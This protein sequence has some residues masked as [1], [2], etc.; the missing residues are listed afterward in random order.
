MTAAA[1]PE[2]WLVELDRSEAALEALERTTPR[3]SDDIRARLAA[4]AAEDARRE[5]RLA[6][7]ALRILLERRLGSGIRNTPF[8]VAAKGKPSLAGVDAS[9][10]LAHT[11]QTALIGI[12]DAGPIGVD[13]ERSRPLWMPEARRAPIEAE[14]VALAAGAPLAEPDPDARFLKAWVRIEAAA[15]ADGS[16]VGARLEHLRPGRERVSAGAAA[17]SPEQGT[18]R[19]IVHDIAAGENLFAAVALPAGVPPPPLRNLPATAAAI[20]ALL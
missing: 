15:K 13:I 6:H 3:L 20:E 4:I 7:I 10:S 11:R 19:V 14:A 17:P 16:G 5:R 2:L 9:F 1:G 12:A 8:V 18:P